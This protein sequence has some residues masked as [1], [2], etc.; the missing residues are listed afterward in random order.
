MLSSFFFTSIFLQFIITDAWCAQDAIMPQAHISLK[1]TAARS[2]SNE[3]SPC[4]SVFSVCRGCKADWTRWCLNVLA[5]EYSRPVGV[6]RLIYSTHQSHVVPPSFPKVTLRLQPCC[7]CASVC[8]AV[9]REILPLRGAPREQH[10]QQNAV[11]GCWIP[12][13]PPQIQL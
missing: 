1:Q 13:G 6:C 10:H 12:L 9:Q 2:S 4:W 7:V 3:S 11:F 5:G 8:A